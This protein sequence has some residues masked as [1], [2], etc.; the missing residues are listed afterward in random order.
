MD[1]L[2]LLA[3]QRQT[4]LETLAALKIALTKINAAIIQELGL[5]PAKQKR[6]RPSLKL[7]KGNLEKTG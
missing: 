4:I 2:Q 3:T 7:F 1:H 5:E 6:G